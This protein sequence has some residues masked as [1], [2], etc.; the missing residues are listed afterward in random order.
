MT[1]TAEEFSNLL[2]LAATWVE[3]QEQIALDN[4]I[5]LTDSQLIDARAVQVG[6]P[7]RVRLLK[8][9]AVPIPSHP[10]LKAVCDNTKAITSTTKALSVRYGI[11]I[12]AEQWHDRQFVVHEL[13]HTAQYERFG[14]IEAFL[15]EYLAECLTFGYPHGAM[16][17]EAIR[18]AARICQTEQLL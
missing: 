4:G 10:I 15:R 12:R 11:L 3:G 13:V 2:S 18:T 9:S 1:F 6:N 14:G 7:E 5:P 17:Q 16:E 8:V